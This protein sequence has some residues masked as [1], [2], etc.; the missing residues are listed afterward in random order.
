MLT[1]IFL[2][3]CSSENAQSLDSAQLRQ[4]DKFST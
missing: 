4:V 2:L 3:I 1:N